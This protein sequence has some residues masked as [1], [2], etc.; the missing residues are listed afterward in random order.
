M[1][2]RRVVQV[3]AVLVGAA[4]TFF[5][6][7]NYSDASS[8]WQEAVRVEVE[9]AGVHQDEVRQVYANEGPFAFRVAVLQI[10]AA[11]L[12][13]LGENARTE[14]TIAENSAFA[15]RQ[16]SDP[17]SLL[18]QRRYDLPGGGSDLA[19]RLA[20]LGA[21]RE[22]PLPDPDVPD[23]EG[24][25]LALAAL[26]IS[27]ITVL[28]TGVAVAGA[29]VRGRESSL[30]LVPQPGAVPE[31]ERR[32]TFL[33]LAVWAAGVLL[34]LTQLAFSSLEQR[35]QAD[36]A[37]HAVQARSAESI[38]ST[39]T[40]FRVTSLQIAREGSVAATAREIDAVYGDARTAAR[41]L[42]RAE[43]DAATRSEA[44]AERMA[45]TDGVE[46]GLATALTSRPHNWAALKALSDRE[47]DLADVYGMV[48][49]TML[50]LIGFLVLA[51]VRVHL[52]AERRRRPQ[53]ERRSLAR[54]DRR[55]VGLFCLAV[56]VAVAL[57]LARRRRTTG[58][59]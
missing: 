7:W 14:R 27:V 32:L 40:E 46:S 48:S 43:A 30:Q 4:C 35:H 33:L 42:A 34:P 45:R 17:T 57:W 15:L 44:V 10:R 29:S 59:E 8:A 39:R 36:S 3:V 16:A 50:G 28:V 11:A 22:K 49:N 53:P 25:E 37:R 38:S 23:R 47:A 13:P 9:K 12:A 19:R 26:W 56:A 21:K 31:Q 6:G 1:R 24:D 55:T 2:A 5:A 41:D 20:D 58:R 52:V 54:R 18:G 51:E